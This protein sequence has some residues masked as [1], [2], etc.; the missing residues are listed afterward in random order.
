MN[1]FGPSLA[2]QM[3]INAKSDVNQSMKDGTTPILVAFQNGHFE[4]IRNTLI[5]KIY[6]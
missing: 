2:F 1:I 5:H 3:L 4:C 6:P